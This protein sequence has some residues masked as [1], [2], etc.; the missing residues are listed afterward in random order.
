M[1]STSPHAAIHGFFG[2]VASA[3]EPSTG[4]RT[5]STSPA[6]AVA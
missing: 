3:M 5:A 6:A 4:E 2:P 1:T